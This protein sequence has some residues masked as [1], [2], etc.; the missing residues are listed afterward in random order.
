L[1]EEDIHCAYIHLI[2]QAAFIMKERKAALYGR[3]K[4]QEI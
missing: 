2:H 4:Q 1:K 3:K